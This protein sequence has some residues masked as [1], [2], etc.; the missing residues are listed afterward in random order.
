MYFEI[1]AS[2]NS[3]KDREGKLIIK[4]RNAVVMGRNISC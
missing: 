2:S 1:N 4:N 3:Y